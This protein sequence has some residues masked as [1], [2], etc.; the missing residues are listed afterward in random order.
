MILKTLKAFYFIFQGL[1]GIVATIFWL[2][3][4]AAGIITIAWV[5]TGIQGTYPLFDF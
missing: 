5:F 2:G 1:Y 4:I 3:V